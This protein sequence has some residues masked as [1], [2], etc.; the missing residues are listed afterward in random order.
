MKRYLDAGS[1]TV[2]SMTFIL[3]VLALFTKGMTHDLLLEAGVLLVS[4]K[5]IMMAYRTGTYYQ[6]I[7]GELKDIKEALN[8]K[9]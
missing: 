6:S 3:F 7:L 9:I 8:K 5:L 4:V 1:I 2:I